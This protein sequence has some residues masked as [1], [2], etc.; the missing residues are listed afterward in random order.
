MRADLG[1]AWQ[2][3]MDHFR[4]QVFQMQVNMILLLRPMPRPSRISIV[5]ERLTTS[6]E[7]RSLA[8]RCVTF[9]EAFTLSIGQVAA[10]TTHT[11]GNQAS[12]DP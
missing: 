12:R 4:T 6:R 5:I 11:F 9:H 1:N 2:T 10:F 8:D 3:F 7:A